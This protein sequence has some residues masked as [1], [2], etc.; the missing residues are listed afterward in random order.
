[1][2]GLMMID[3]VIVVGAGASGIVAAIFA[4][5]NGARVRILEHKESPGK[6]LLL[7]GNGKCNLSRRNLDLDLY[8]GN[9]PSFPKKVL[10]QYS[11]EQTLSF[12]REIAILCK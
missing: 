9:H 1:M 2:R 12:F 6:K 3:D 10:C 8:R 4:A 7:T 11:P 5:R